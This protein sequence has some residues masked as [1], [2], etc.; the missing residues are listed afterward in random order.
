[1]CI[2]VLTMTVIDLG[3]IKSLQMK[4][5]KMQVNIC[6]ESQVWPAEF[7]YRILQLHLIYE[8]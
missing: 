3:K 1:M 8:D 4:M 5:Q 2:H 7:S 6:I